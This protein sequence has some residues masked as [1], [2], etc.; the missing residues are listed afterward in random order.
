M[1]TVN[2]APSFPLTLTL[3][4]Q[5]REQKLEL[6]Y[7]HKTRD[8]YLALLEKVRSEEI[9]PSD[10]VMAL[11]ESWKADAELTKDVLDKLAQDMPGTDWAIITAFGDAQQVARKGNSSPR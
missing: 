8:E 3:T 7:R 1:F 9:T 4:G 11:V 6:V 5:G 10:V 2:P